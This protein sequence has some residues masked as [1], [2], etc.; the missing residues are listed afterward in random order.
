MR[1]TAIPGEGARSR[2]P[3]ALLGGGGRHDHDRARGVVGALLADRSQDEPA[4][5]AEPT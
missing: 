5:A 4:E 1:P 3:A 2:T